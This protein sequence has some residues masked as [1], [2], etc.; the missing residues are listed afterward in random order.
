MT[1]LD[2]RELE[3][4]A[5][6]AFLHN[7]TPETFRAFFEVMYVKLVRYFLIRK[8]E[9]RIAEELAQE[10]LMAIYRKRDTLREE[11]NFFGWLFRIARNRLLQY[12]RDD[13]EEREI[14]V[15]PS[16][17]NEYAKPVEPT[18]PDSGEF[19][20]WM[21]L[22]ELVERQVMML[23]YIEDL[24]YQ[25]IADVLSLPIGTVKWKI[26]DAKEKLRPVLAPRAPAI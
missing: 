22:L 26:F 13:R 10:V 18:P 21:K 15:E 25:E 3:R 14:Q 23:R 1:T 5:V 7:S 17:L 20:T 2:S 4:K 19:L 9:R 6:A 11:E 8:V 16:E 24:G 12:L